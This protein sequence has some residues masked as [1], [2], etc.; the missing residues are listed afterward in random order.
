[1][2]I[3]PIH[4]ACRYITRVFLSPY[5]FPELFYTDLRWCFFYYNLV[6]PYIFIFWCRSSLILG[7]SMVFVILYFLITFLSF[8]VFGSLFLFILLSI[9]ISPVVV[10]ILFSMLI[11]HFCL[12][13]L[14]CF[15]FCF[16]LT[17]SLDST[18]FAQA[19]NIVLTSFISRSISP[20]NS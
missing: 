1:M 9:D 14:S 18:I 20:R 15:L 2:S 10:S 6:S 19:Y 7:I 8:L 13:F 11:F 12:L 4:P 5:L 17:Q 3:F 16:G